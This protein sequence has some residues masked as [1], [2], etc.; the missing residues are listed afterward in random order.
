M[1]TDSG[2]VYISNAHRKT[3]KSLLLQVY[4]KQYAMASNIFKWRHFLYFFLL[5]QKAEQSDQQS[6][7]W[8][9]TC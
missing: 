5:L 2:D 6:N 7:A 9:I 3:N 8:L 4:S 1:N